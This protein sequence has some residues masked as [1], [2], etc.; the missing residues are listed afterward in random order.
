MCQEQRGTCDFPLGV[1]RLVGVSHGTQEKQKEKIQHNWGATE[2]QGPFSVLPGSPDV[3]GASD[4]GHL[5]FVCPTHSPSLGEQLIADH[6][7]RP[8]R[9]VG[10]GADLPPGLSVQAHEP[11]GTR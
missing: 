3:H 5:C 10:D 8:V 6:S 11:G 7:P 4:G 2:Q 9:G 1:Y